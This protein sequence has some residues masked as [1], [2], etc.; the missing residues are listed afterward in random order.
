MRQ[1][2]DQVLTH[3]PNP[4]PVVE[5]TYLPLPGRETRCGS[6]AEGRVA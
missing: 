2:V 4:L 6:V 3:R 5:Q 1:A